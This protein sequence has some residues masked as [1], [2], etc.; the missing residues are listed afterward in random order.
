M[1]A[2]SLEQFDVP[3]ILSIIFHPRRDS[4]APDPQRDI[5][6]QVEEGVSLGGR[7]HVCSPDAPLILFFHGNGEIASD[8]NDVAPVYNQLGINFLVIDFRGY[9]SSGGSPTLSNLVSDA[10][11]VYDSLPRLLKERELAPSRIFV[12]GRSLGSASAIEIASHAGDRIQGLI[13]ESGF[14]YGQRL[15]ASLGGPKMSAGEDGKV[16]TAAL[17]KMPNIK[18]PTLIL[19]GEADFII[20]VD[21]AHALHEHSGASA[22]RLVTIPAAG[23]NDLLFTGQAQY[24]RAI[25]ELIAQ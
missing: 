2:D 6:I 5:E 10:R 1:T 14:A 20:P 13:I 15:I 9:G 21:D 22:K 11:K 19:H 4:S 24:F 18:V 25:A 7:I 3:E 17:A 8:Y 12:M 16:G 23:H